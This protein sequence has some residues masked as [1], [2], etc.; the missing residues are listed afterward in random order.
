VTVCEMRIAM[1][2]A[3]WRQSRT[4]VTQFLPK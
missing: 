2:V 4:R 1:L 3:G